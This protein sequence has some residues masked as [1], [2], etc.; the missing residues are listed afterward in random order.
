MA[1][2]K[3][4][5][6]L[7][8]QLQQFEDSVRV[9]C[10]RVRDNNGI[11]SGNAALFQIRENPF[12]PDRRRTAAPAVIQ[13][14]KTAALH[15]QRIALA[16]VQRCNGKRFPGTVKKQNTG[17]KHGNTKEHPLP[18]SCL[19]TF[20]FCP[21]RIHLPFSFSHI[22]YHQQT[23]QNDSISCHLPFFRLTA[24]PHISRN[25]CDRRCHL[26]QK[27]EQEPRRKQ[28][29]TSRFHACQSRQKPRSTRQQHRRHDSSCKQIRQKRKERNLIKIPRL[30]RDHDKLQGK[31]HHRS[32][33]SFHRKLFQPRFF[34]AS[35]P[36][37]LLPRQ[38][39]IN[40]GNGCYCSK[41]KP[42][43]ALLQ[44]RGVFRQH[45]NCRKR[46]RT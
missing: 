37:H 28:N 5:F 45:Q 8:D 29:N 18:P 22:Q 43:P 41:R 39:R 32:L 25:L 12:F 11:K 38:N 10:I 27:C 9:I 44:I 46:E 19:R 17:K 1:D 14:Q 3:R 2:A 24:D 13:H 7:P 40:P 42:E 34:P 6:L 20:S 30:Q 21:I 26:P 4:R 35:L 36:F 15:H 33:F 16:D 23:G 31:V